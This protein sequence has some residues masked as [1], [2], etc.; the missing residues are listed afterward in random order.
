[1]NWGERVLWL[2]KVAR[3]LLIRGVHGYQRYLGFLLGG[4]CRFF[5]TCS[6]YAEEALQHGPLLRAL[7][8]TSWRLLRCQPL[9][10]GGMDPVPESPSGDRYHLSPEEI[11]AGWPKIP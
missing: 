7:W 5:P 2:D 11:E 9:C 8:L 6:H 3:L 10:K 4:Q 1:M